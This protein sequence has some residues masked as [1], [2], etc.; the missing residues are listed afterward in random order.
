MSE[1]KSR[2]A[3]TYNLASSGYDQEAV[4]FFSLCA[5]RLVELVSLQPGQRML[6]VATGTGAAAIA[7][8]RRV[9]PTGHVIGVDI[10]T[11]MMAQAHRKVESE[12]LTNIEFQM[13]M[14]NI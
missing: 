1:H 4:R 11:E 8:A 12:Q 2:V 3:A 9:G 10:A 13:V 14:L 5:S 6:D 7:A